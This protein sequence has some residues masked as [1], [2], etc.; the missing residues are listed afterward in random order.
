M[1]LP[2]PTLKILFEN[3]PLSFN[4][5]DVPSV[6]TILNPRSSKS[7]ATPIDFILSFSLTD[8]NTVHFVGKSEPALNSAFA[9]AEPRL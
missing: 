1:G 5:L 3:T 4:S 9:N 6:A 8:I 2:S 7:R